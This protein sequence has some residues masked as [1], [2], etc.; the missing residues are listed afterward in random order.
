MIYIVYVFVW[1]HGAMVGLSS[2]SQTT[3]YQFIKKAGWGYVS[4]CTRSLIYTQESSRVSKLPAKND[5]NTNSTKIILA[6]P[7]FADV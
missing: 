3:I 1:V 7:S 5:N 2:Y 4:L 6:W